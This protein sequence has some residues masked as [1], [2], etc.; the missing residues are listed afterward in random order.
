MKFTIRTAGFE[1]SIR[2][3]SEFLGL[4]SI[5][6][7][8]EKTDRGIIFEIGD[9]ARI[10]ISE[11]YA[12]D[13]NYRKEFAE[14]LKSEKVDIQLKVDELGHWIKKLEKHNWPYRGPVHRPWGSTYVYL[15]DPD[16]VKIILFQGED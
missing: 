9:S 5:E 1:K 10:E 4:E 15:K 7:W 8:N 12:Q 2:F 16:G 3:Y 14:I 11:V 13:E 6:S